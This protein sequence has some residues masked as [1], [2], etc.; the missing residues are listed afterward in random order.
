MV[1]FLIFVEFMIS[2]VTVAATVVVVSE[3]AIPV[4]VAVKLVTL[5]AKVVIVTDAQIAV[6][7]V[8][9]IVSKVVIATEANSSCSSYR[10]S[11][12]CR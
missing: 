6:I 8:V 1:G 2:L 10:S 11:N 7:A 5:M 4:V 3:V 12:S 9:S